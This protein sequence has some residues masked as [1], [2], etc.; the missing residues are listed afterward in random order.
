MLNKA[1]RTQDIELLFLFRFLIHDIYEQLK[2]YQY[3]SLIRVY[4]GQAMS[5]EE[6][7]AL[8]RSIK[9]LISINSFFSTSVDYY[10]ALD[11][12]NDSYISNDLHRVLFVIDAH[13]HV[14]STKPFADISSHSPYNEREVLFMVGCVFRITDIRQ[15]KQTWMIYMQLCGDDE[16]DMQDLFQHMKKE[17]AGGDKEVDLRSFGAVLYKMGKYNLAEMVYLRLLHELS[18]NDP[19]LSSVY[20]SL[21]MVYEEKGQYTTSLYWYQNSLQTQMKMNPSNHVDIGGIHCCIGV[22]Y[23]K[24][25]DYKRALDYYYKAIELFQKA[26]DDN[27]PDMASF[28]NNIAIIYNNQKQ[29]S[30]ALDFYEKMLSIETKH[31]PPDHPNLGM[32]YNNIGLVYYSA[33]D[34]NLAMS[35]YNRSL[36][37]KLKSLP[38]DHPLIATSYVNIG[39]VHETTNNL[40]QALVYFQK[41]AAIRHKAFAFDNPDVIKIDKDIQRVLSKINR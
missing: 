8:Q 23:K 16:H 30:R 25:G 32:S 33:G 37:I 31:L 7:K 4:R 3:H 26:H 34:Y 1:L 28:Y 14:V 11:F 18:S 27:H 22:V 12:L 29:F 20:R 2:Q 35:Y 39:R 9:K 21:G 15:D 36:Q 41:A 40:Q 24:K 5:H 19:M 38:S 17:Y 6:L 10:K 13:P